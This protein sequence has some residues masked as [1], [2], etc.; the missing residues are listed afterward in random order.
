VASERKG[1]GPNSESVIGVACRDVLKRGIG[2]V[3]YRADNTEVR[4]TQGDTTND[5]HDDDEVSRRRNLGLV[6][7]DSRTADSDVEGH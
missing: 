2:C 5:A 7:E 4:K 1:F 3:L 6:D